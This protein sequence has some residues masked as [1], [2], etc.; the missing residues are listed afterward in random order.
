MLT[1][2][3]ITIS[4]TEQ[5]ITYSVMTIRVNHFAFVSQQWSCFISP[6][7]NDNFP[8][9]TLN[10]IFNLLLISR[11]YRFYLPR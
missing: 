3:G 9:K 7:C 4:D 11:P 8:R 1:E 2:Q 10:Y 6:I 5:G